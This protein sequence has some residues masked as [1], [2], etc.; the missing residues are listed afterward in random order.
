MAI[1]PM[2]KANDEKI[3]V[4]TEKFSDTAKLINRIVMPTDHRVRH[5]PTVNPKVR[6]G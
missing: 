3:I 5:V 4:V 2:Q 1:H 6:G